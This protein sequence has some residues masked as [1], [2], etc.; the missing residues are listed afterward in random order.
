L[1]KV[2]FF[3]ADAKILRSKIDESQAFFFAKWAIRDF[4]SSSAA[5][6]VQRHLAKDGQESRQSQNPDRHPEK[7]IF[8]FRQFMI[9]ASLVHI[10]VLLVHG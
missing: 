1:Q 5:P 3:A 10:L 8:W 4:S 7:K 9:V 2:G 6:L